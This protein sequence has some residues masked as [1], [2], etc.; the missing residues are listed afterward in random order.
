MVTVTTLS[1]TTPP[2][3]VLTS[4]STGRITRRAGNG[5]N[6]A[7]NYAL[8]VEVEAKLGDIVIAP[9]HGPTTIRFE[10][11]TEADRF[12]LAESSKSMLRSFEK[13][14]EALGATDALREVLT[15]HEVLGAYRDA[16]GNLT[17]A[18]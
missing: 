9:E 13:W 16:R 8:W 18:R 11:V 15:I 12:A 14:V 4:T 2:I 7:G 6:V 10:R 1:T 5:R 3:T 17:N